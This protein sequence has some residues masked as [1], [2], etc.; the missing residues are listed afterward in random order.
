[1][2]MTDSAIGCEITDWELLEELFEERSAIIEYDGK[3]PRYEA[4]QLAAQFLGF[5][6][7]AKLKRHVQVLK[8]GVNG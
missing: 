5:D 7:K 3:K 6:N 8:A 1:M 2:S 4:E